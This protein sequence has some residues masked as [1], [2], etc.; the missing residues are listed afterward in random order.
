MFDFDNNDCELKSQST[1]HL[2]PTTIDIGIHHRHLPHN[3]DNRP[4]RA[5]MKSSQYSPRKNH[6]LPLTNSLSPSKNRSSHHSLRFLK[7]RF[8]R[9]AL[10]SLV[11]LR[12]MSYVYWMHGHV[13]A[14]RVLDIMSSNDEEEY[15]RKVEPPI[16][17]VP[18][19]SQIH[20]I[21]PAI[22]P[23]LKQ[24]QS[25]RNTQRYINQDAV[26]ERQRRTRPPEHSQPIVSALNAQDI[27]GGTLSKPIVTIP[28][29]PTTNSTFSH[30]CVSAGLDAN[31]HVVIT[32]ALR[33][34][35]LALFFAKH[36]G[37]RRI[38]AA[39]DAFPNTRRHRMNILHEQV[40]ALQRSVDQFAFK[41]VS[42]NDYEWSLPKNATHIVHLDV[43]P[44]FTNTT[45]LLTENNLQL[46][47]RARDQRMVQRLVQT[48]TNARVLHVTTASSVTSVWTAFARDHQQ[49]AWSHLILPDTAI[50][51]PYASDTIVRGNNE[52]MLLYVEDAVVAIL[53]ALAS[54]NFGTVFQVEAKPQ[55]FEQQVLDTNAYM[56]QRNDPF[57]IQTIKTRRATTSAVVSDS[58]Y[59]SRFGAHPTLFPCASQCGH[60][61]TTDSAFTSSL[62]QIS[63]NATM[64]CE[65][66]VYM[67]MLSPSIASVAKT[68]GHTVDH[69]CRVAFVTRQSKLVKRAL[70]QRL[71]SNS[72]NSS[73]SWNGK[74]VESRWILVWLPDDDEQS[75]NDADNALLRIDPSGMFAPTV[76]AAVYAESLEF[77]KA[78]DESILSLFKRMSQPA[79]SGQ[80]RRERRSGT[81]L[82]RWV[83]V[84]PEPA[85]KAI[86]FAGEPT[87]GKAV[88]KSIPDFVKMVGKHF[89]FPSRQLNYY[90]QVAS[91]VQSNDVRP[92]SESRTTKYS[93]FPFAWIS[94]SVLIHDFQTRESQELR[95]AWY[96]EYLFWGGN[97]DAEELS[98]AYVLGKQRIEESLGA[99]LAGDESSWNPLV[100][101]QTNQRRTTRGDVELFIRILKRSSKK[102]TK[103]TKK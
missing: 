69:F 102:K 44:S 76:K 19:V 58:T 65:Y 75:L 14:R 21:H 97:R 18:T 26:L 31:S 103:E 99:P 94:T 51:G 79:I 61:C 53:K 59:Q 37:V 57:G 5:R 33:L 70:A 30:Y 41:V 34:P 92:T 63:R 82:S 88:P 84:P 101:P 73:S 36:C 20:Q 32:N 81:S 48:K 45:D 7:C 15:Q 28:S 72:T 77:A 1:S 17:L 54:F 2:H 68:S 52:T 98:L 25:S 64:G 29:I 67:V 35:A 39:D 4:G 11:F 95:C 6:V 93:T 56:Q 83:P 10:V 62:Q 8:V 71:T 46:Y 12:L 90:Q 9:R 91:M 24:Q 22:P 16:L 78:R 89:Y 40:R 55:L 43:V 96:D 86:L 49:L 60:M 80:H 47:K 87:S 50:V 66:V 74:I 38:T 27:L 85:R 100:S 3:N 42:L 23:I 13:V